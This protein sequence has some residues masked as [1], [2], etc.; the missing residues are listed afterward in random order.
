MERKCAE[1]ARGYMAQAL[2]H[3]IQR[4]INANHVQ[5]QIQDI[6]YGIVITG[7]AYHVQIQHGENNRCGTVQNVHHVRAQRQVITPQQANA[8]LARHQHHIMQ[9]Q[10]K[11]A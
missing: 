9:V 3:G 11:D 7:D 5:A 1:I 8:K 10:W 6:R 2:L 4:H